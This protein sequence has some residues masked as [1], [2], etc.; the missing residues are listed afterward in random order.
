MDVNF[1][2]F[3]YLP[4]FLRFLSPPFDAAF[5]FGVVAID[6]R[7]GDRTGTRVYLPLWYLPLAVPRISKAASDEAHLLFMSIY[8]TKMLYFFFLRDSGV[9]RICVR[10]S[11]LEG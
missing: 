9:T 7:V 8:S 10:R 4:F 1:K 3:T 6:L 11:G 5:S 2:K